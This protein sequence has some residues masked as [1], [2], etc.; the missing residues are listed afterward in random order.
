M[1][2]QDF[3]TELKTINKDLSIRPNNVTNA[4]VLENYPDVN[5]LASILYCGVEICTIPNENIYDEKSGS[6]GV[7]MRGDGTFKAHRT[8]PEA[9][10]IVKEKLEALKDK[11]YADSFFGRGEYSDAELRKDEKST[12]VMTV[13]EAEAK[14]IQGGTIEGA[15]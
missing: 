3:E 10:S 6:Y 1:T 15:K 2:I 5:K 11:D 8:R 13:V 14:P 7:D 12:Q 4:R 9:L